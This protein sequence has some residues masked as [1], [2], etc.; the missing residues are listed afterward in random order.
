MKNLLVAFLFSVVLFSCQ[1]EI[2][3]PNPFI[4][5]SKME[6]ILYDVALLYAIQSTN[7]FENDTIK[8]IGMNDVFKKYSIDSLSFTENNRYYISLKKGV[9][10]TMQGR[11]MERLK[12]EKE[13]VDSLSA[14]SNQ[15]KIVPLKEIRDTLTVQAV[16]NDLHQAVEEN[17]GLPLG[18]V[19]ESSNKGAKLKQKRL[20][21]DKEK[22]SVKKI[23]TSEVG[24]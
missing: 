10:Y 23:E 14:K 7:S 4:E 18:E 13:Q 12:R 22:V 24:K 6:D 17:T 19:K 3:K 21:L 15:Q 5:E 2:E 1:K 9:Y 8:A 11:I 20:I 16:R